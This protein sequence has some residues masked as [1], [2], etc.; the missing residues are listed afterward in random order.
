L[1]KHLNHR[2]ED[3]ADARQCLIYGIDLARELR[4]RSIEGHHGSVEGV[5]S[6]GDEILEERR[7]LVKSIAESLEILLDR[8]DRAIDR[9]SKP[10][11]VR[12]IRN[13]RRRCCGDG[14]RSHAEAKGEF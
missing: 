8:R 9:I 7:K 11:E 10:E 4:E 14:K 12:L 13:H 6:G 2:T 3:V 5:N 1:T